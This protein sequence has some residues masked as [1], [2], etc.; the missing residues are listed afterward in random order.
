MYL[1]YI[2]IFIA[3]LCWGFLGILGRIAMASEL[4]PLDVAFWRAFLG[5]MF[6]LVHA[7][8]I[9][10]IKLHSTS[11][12][13]GFTFFGLFSIASFFAAYQYAINEGGVALA[14]VLLYTA[15]A[16]VAF[17][18]RIF[19]GLA[20]TKVTAFAIFIAL[21]GVGCISF[22][23][24]PEVDSALA[25]VVAESN[26]SLHSS[27]PIL[28]ILFGLL[29]GFLYATHYVVTK[30]YLK[31]YSPFTLYG[32]GSLVAA[33]CLFPFIDLNLNLTLNTW[34]ALLGIAFLSTYLAYWA[35]CEAI[36]R[37]HPT[38]TAIIA[39]LE[40]VVATIAAYYI[41]G[42]NFTYLGWFGAILILCTVFILLIDDKKR[43]KQN[44]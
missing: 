15:P 19:F 8:C 11:D 7:Y 20:F 38:K 28:G 9:K 5:G 27:L 13:I 40:P 43:A 31:T 39:N 14:S 44:A 25:P 26:L 2:F 4:A 10:D 23:S 37:L 36:K 41:Y 32:Y 42:E 35:Y 17:F 30:K 29:S 33:L 3:A 34:L 1:G 21:I 24:T 16:W 18:S 12:A 22:S 6:M